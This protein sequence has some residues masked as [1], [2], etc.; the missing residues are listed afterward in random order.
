[1]FCL[2]LFVKPHDSSGHDEEHNVN[3]NYHNHWNNEGPDELGFW[4]H[5]T[6][7]E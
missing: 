5:E 1:M 7:V 3:K 4:I 2:S 6:A